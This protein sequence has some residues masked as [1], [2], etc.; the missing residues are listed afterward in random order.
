MR[1]RSTLDFALYERAGSTVFPID[2]V[3]FGSLLGSLGAREH[4]H[5]LSVEY[6]R[7]QEIELIAAV[8][9][10][11]ATVFAASYMKTLGAEFAKWTVEELK[12][13]RNLRHAQIKAGRSSVLVSRNGEK[14][15]AEAIATLFAGAAKRKGRIEIVFERRR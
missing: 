6:R 1:T 14:K 11:G 13:R 2:D 9:V 4:S 8:F 10:A 5:V 3:D 15:A 12:R 7:T